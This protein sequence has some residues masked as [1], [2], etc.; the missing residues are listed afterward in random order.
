MPDSLQYKDPH[1]WSNYLLRSWVEEILDSAEGLSKLVL[2][3]SQQSD[4]WHPPAK[5]LLH[6][7][8]YYSW[9]CLQGMVFWGQLTAEQKVC[10][11]V[12][13]QVWS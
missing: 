5:E 7:L 6:V 1:F 12:R 8:L 2:S 3:K 4:C 11:I 9:F 13:A 10:V